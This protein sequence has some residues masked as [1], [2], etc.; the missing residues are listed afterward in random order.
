M[1][2][3]IIDSILIGDELLDGSIADQNAIFLGRFL[4]DVG[5]ELR[6]IRVI[7]DGVDTI[8]DALEASDADFIVVSGGLGPTADDVTREAAAL[9]ASDELERDERVLEIMKKRFAAF[10]YTF[11]PN[12]QRQAMFPR[13]AAV[14]D[15]EVGTA[16]GF[17]LEN[18]NQRAW[19][20]PGVPSEFRWFCRRDFAEHLGVES[21]RIKRSLYFHGRGESGL[22]SSLEGIERVATDADVRVGYRAEYPVIELKLVGAP[23]NV[24][25]V[26]EFALDR[27]GPWWVGAD[28][29]TLEARIGRRLKE[30]GEKVTT[31]ESCTAGGIAARITDVPG[32]SAY[33]EEGFV[34]YSNDAKVELIAVDPRVLE[35]HGAVSAQTV[36]QMAAGARA[37][38]GADWAIAVSG[39]AG[40]GG[41]TDEKPVGLV[42]FGLAGK[43]GVWHRRVHFRVQTRERIRSGTVY[44]ALSLLLWALEDRLDEHTVTGP[45]A[46][47]EVMSE[48][49]ISQEIE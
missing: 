2:R 13:S 32:S 12:N 1:P 34:T 8:R 5:H 14:L 37:R 20:F 9:W 33:F 44:S 3:P 6:Q 10:G 18:G 7:R 22:E 25:I 11:T 24:R 4:A 26:E 27:I 46:L 45:H 30:R 21:G 38:A 36:C 29:E 41:G 16:A 43:E 31:A 15:T 23:E 42:H 39:I 49:G 19:F 28:A 47:E 17:R 35:S 40:P 48:S